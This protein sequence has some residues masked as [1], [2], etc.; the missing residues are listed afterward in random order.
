MRDIHQLDAQDKMGVV[1][2]EARR[3]QKPSIWNNY[4]VSDRL[5]VNLGIIYQDESFM[6]NPELMEQ[7]MR[8]Y[9]STPVSMLEPPMA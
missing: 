5:A 3:M 9:P 2:K 6:K 1:F 4:L 7:S 8:N